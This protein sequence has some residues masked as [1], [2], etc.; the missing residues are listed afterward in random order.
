[1]KLYPKSG[2]SSAITGYDEYSDRIYVRYR[3]GKVYGYSYESAGVNQV[4]EMKRLAEMGEGLAR[5]ITNNV[6]NDFF[7]RDDESAPRPVP[8]ARSREDKGIAPMPAKLRTFDYRPLVES[9]ELSDRYPE[10]NVYYSPSV[11]EDEKVP[12]L[13]E[14]IIIEHQHIMKF[15]M[16]F[17]HTDNLPWQISIE[18]SDHHVVDCT[19][20][21][22]DRQ[23]VDRIQEAF[24]N[25]NP[26][27]MEIERLLAERK[28]KYN[29]LGMY[30][31]EPSHIRLFYRMFDVSKGSDIYL[32][33]IRQTLV[34]ELL[35]AKHHMDAYKTFSAQGMEA[36]RTKEALADFFAFF[37]TQNPGTCWWGPAISNAS[38]RVA[39][40]RLRA[41][42]RKFGGSW[43]YAYA[44]RFFPVD[45]GKRMTDLDEGY[46][47]HLCISKYMDVWGVSCH[48]MY[49]A[50]ELLMR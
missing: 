40:D 15:M 48:N 46:V 44:L 7:Y 33:Q 10:L 45:D 31:P 19:G 18:L 22:T 11:S 30:Q 9:Q 23:I 42:E 35:H 17:F 4:E 36:V 28:S 50:Y 27:P 14:F 41:W 43:P 5:Y 1:M 26:D 29:L 3:G 49:G 47:E 24:R 6:K 20:T 2:N 8:D 13:R 38:V 37:Y 21:M 25:G 34:H 32:A 12:G 16:E 39:T